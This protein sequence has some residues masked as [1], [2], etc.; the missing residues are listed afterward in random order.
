[1]QEQLINPH[2]A[3]FADHPGFEVEE[4]LDCPH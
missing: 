4:D 1:M 2:L 3:R